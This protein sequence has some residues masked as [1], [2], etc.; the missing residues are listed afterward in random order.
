MQLKTTTMKRKLKIGLH[1]E[2]DSVTFINPQNPSSYF[3]IEAIDGGQLR[4]RKA[5]FTDTDQ[6]IITPL[7]QNTLIIK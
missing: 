2:N 1:N 6:I 7:V 5:G 3:E 4:I